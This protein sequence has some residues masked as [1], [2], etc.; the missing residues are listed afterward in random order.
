MRLYIFFQ[1]SNCA[2]LMFFLCRHGMVMSSSSLDFGVWKLPWN[3]RWP[4]LNIVAAEIT[5]KT[6]ISRNI[7]SLFIC[8]FIVCFAVRYTCRE[9]MQRYRVIYKTETTKKG[10]EQ[11]EL[12]YDKPLISLDQRILLIVLCFLVG[13]RQ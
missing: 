6:G 13:K 5:F 3:Q 1:T 4:D 10:R 2:K 12:I 7:L 8:L 11:R 9:P